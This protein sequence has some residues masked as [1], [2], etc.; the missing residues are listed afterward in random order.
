MRDADSRGSSRIRR[1][2]FLWLAGFAL[3]V[4][5]LWAG[6]GAGAALVVARDASPPDAI[7]MLASHEWERLPAAAAVARLYPSSRVL[8]TVP[9]KVTPWNCRNCA[10]RPHQFQ[11]QGVAAARIVELTNYPA[12]NTYGEAIA[13]RRYLSDRGPIKTLLIVTSPYHTRRALH[14]FQHVLEPAGVQV[15]IHPAFAVSPANPRRWWLGVYDREYVPYEWA[16]IFYYRVK[17]GVP[18]T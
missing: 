12:E 1:R 4:F 11:E 5:S 14:T 17:Y 7:V 13:V 2:R 18:L 10:G 15:G 6:I 8:L 3:L 16:G 9:P